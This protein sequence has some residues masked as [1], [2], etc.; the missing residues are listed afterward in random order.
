MTEARRP[1]LAGR[2]GQIEI[3]LPNAGRFLFAA[4]GNPTATQLQMTQQALGCLRPETLAHL[5]NGTKRR[6]PLTFF[7]TSAQV[8]RDVVARSLLGRF[9]SSADKLSRH[10][11]ACYYRSAIWLPDEEAGASWD[12]SQALEEILH[13]VLDFSLHR[14]TR[15]KF[16]RSEW[17]RSQWLEALHEP[18]ERHWRNH[19]RALGIDPAEV[20]TF[21]ELK[22]QL[23][24]D[25]NGPDETLIHLQSLHGRFEVL[26]MPHDALIEGPLTSLRESVEEYLVHAWVAYLIENPA[27]ELNRARLE[28]FDQPLCWAMELMASIEPIVDSP[29]PGFVRE[30]ARR[31]Q[32]A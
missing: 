18:L 11:D 21:I 17:L 4:V 31:L 5:Q 26:G 20:K 8:Y 27:I 12:I 25:P 16:W 19:L 28:G 29:T 13:A 32:V 3:S 9:V 22:R 30:L 23:A 15:V 2:R 24:N 14:A 10:T 6:R 7:F 1:D